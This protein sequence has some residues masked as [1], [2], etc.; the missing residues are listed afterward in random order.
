M[1]VFF[2]SS[3]GMW[4]EDMQ[5]NACRIAFTDIY[6]YIYIVIAIAFDT[7]RGKEKGRK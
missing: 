6:I 4:R 7:F 5:L 1:P 2:L 3:I